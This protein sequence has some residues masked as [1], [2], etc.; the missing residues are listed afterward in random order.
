MRAIAANALTILIV[1]GVILAGAALYVRQSFH[2]AG[3]LSEET[4]FVVERGDGLRRVSEE[5]EAAGVVR[6]ALTFRLGAQYYGKSS[7][8][9][10]G[11]YMI[12]PGASME[13]VLDAL[14]KGGAAVEHRFV[15]PEGLSS[16]EIVKRLRAEPLLTGE[17]EVP[18]EG[19]LAPDTYFFRR[20]EAR[21]D[22]LE[23]MIAAQER[24]LDAAWESRAEGLPLESKEEAL[25]LASI[26]EKETGLSSERARVAAVFINRLRR[27]MKLQTDPTVIYG[28]TQGRSTLGRGLRRS[29]LREAT[30]YNTYVIDGLP[31]TPIANPGRL[32]I[33]ATLNPAETDELFFVADGTGGHVFAKTLRE[34]NQNVA[35]WR[36]IEAERRRQNN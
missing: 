36:E 26:V 33:E 29:E 17:V 5:L 35:K 18:P 23:R 32:A 24:I 12:P 1:L 9:R 27:G 31:P 21:A 25:I 14:V 30:P 15:A 34:H 3:P 4:A 10:F 8:I 20:G 6:D 19:A 7:E 28:L 11:E 13:V 2:A 22:V 16:W